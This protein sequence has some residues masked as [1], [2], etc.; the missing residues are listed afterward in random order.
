[1]FTVY[2]KYL[3]EDLDHWPPGYNSNMPLTI[4]EVKHIAKL[5]RLDLTAEEEERY[6]L[7]LSDILDYFLK[8]QQLK[9][10][11]DSLSHGSAKSTAGDRPDIIQS[12]LSIKAVLQNTA[13]QEENQ[14][15]VPPI[16]G[17]Q[18]E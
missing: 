8:L 16:F 18:D 7:Q 2:E 14:F 17:E 1:M 5:A 10:S 13:L 6:R 15:R 11:D 3:A 12:G 4:K 9:I